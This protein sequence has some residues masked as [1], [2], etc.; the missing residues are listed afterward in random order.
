MCSCVC[1]MMDLTAVLPENSTPVLPLNPILVD[2][3]SVYAVVVE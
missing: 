3:Q 1:V 2:D